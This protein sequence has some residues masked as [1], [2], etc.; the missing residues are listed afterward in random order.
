LNEIWLRTVSV[1]AAMSP[2]ASSIALI[3]G[4]VVAVGRAQR[5]KDWLGGDGLSGLGRPG[6]GHP[7]RSLSSHWSRRPL[8]GPRYR[9]GR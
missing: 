9:P 3:G 4:P 5:L 7:R 8:P 6:D 2:A 1:I